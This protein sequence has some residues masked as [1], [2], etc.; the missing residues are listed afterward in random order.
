M[1]EFLLE[2]LRFLVE[3][4]LRVL[5]Y[6]VAYCVGWLVIT[7]LTAGTLPMG[8]LLDE[9]Y[10]ERWYS[11]PCER[12][13]KRNVLSSTVIMVGLLTIAFIAIEAYMLYHGA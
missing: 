7:V 11:L 8:S 6:G 5:L 4:V 10:G 3:P 12:D 13:G 1:A 2:L 9:F